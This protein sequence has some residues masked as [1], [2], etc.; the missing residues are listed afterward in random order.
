MR[1]LWP[2]IDAK[3]LFLQHGIVCASKR[4]FSVFVTRLKDINIFASIIAL[5]DMKNIH[6]A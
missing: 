3:G 5:V 2:V 6:R 4:K 1:W